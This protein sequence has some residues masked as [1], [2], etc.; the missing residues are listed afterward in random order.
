MS[1]DTTECFGS[2]IHNLK[3]C[4]VRGQSIGNWCLIAHLLDITKLCG[5]F[6]VYFCCCPE[7]FKESLK[8]KGNVDQLTRDLGWG[9]QGIHFVVLEA[10][11]QEPRKIG[12]FEDRITS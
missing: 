9:C 3:S 1:N 12:Y 5:K 4:E 6:A 2:E 8:C 7:I 11:A 10:G